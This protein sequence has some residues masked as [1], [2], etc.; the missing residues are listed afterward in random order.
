MIML[1]NKDSI[2][3][4][5]VTGTMVVGDQH[6]Y[7]VEECGMKYRVKMLPFQQKQPLPKEIKCIVH[8]YDADNSPL[9]IR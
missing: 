4:L 9:F 2:Y 5:K 1:Y 8:D 7:L 6:Y 3:N